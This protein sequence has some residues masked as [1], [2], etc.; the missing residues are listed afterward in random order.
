MAAAVSKRNKETHD[1]SGMIQAA[2]TPS[3][4]KGLSSFMNREPKLAVSPIRL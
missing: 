2:L 3:M 1:S 4:H